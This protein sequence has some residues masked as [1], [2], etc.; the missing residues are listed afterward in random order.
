MHFAESE[1]CRGQAEAYRGCCY[2]GERQVSKAMYVFQ[3]TFPLTSYFS[4]VLITRLVASQQ[5]LIINGAIGL[6][7]LVSALITGVAASGSR[8]VRLL[9][10]H[11]KLFSNSNL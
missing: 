9:L 3:S 8:H 4:Q 7:V 2:R 11:M 5:G 6:Q 10:S 1:D